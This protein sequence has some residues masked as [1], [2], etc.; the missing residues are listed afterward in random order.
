MKLRWIASGALASALLALSCCIGPL[1]FMLFGVSMA[2]F[3]FLNVLG[4]YRPL[5]QLLAVTLLGYAWYRYYRRRLCLRNHPWVF[6]ALAVLTV[7]MVFLLYL[8][9]M[10]FE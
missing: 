4:P 6:R 2:S 10:E 1:L 8:P 7:G 3:S 9:Y 5:F